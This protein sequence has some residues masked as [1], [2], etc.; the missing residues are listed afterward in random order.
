[1][2]NKKFLEEN[3]GRICVYNGSV[4]EVVGC[5]DDYSGILNIVRYLSPDKARDRSECW[6][7]LDYGDMIAQGY[8]KPGSVYSYVLQ[9]DLRQVTDT[10]AVRAFAEA[11]K[12]GKF[13]I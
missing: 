8:D 5:L 2:K 11:Y 1:M 4:V 3:L 12:G 7:R 10:D 13:S 9:S 6:T